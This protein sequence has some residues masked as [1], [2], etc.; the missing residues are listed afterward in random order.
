[1]EGP[2]VSGTGHRP[3]KFGGYG[4]N[5]TA[6]EVVA[7]TKSELVRL[8][9]SKVLSGMALGFDQWLAWLC[10]RQGIPFEA[11]LPFE[12]QELVWKDPN[13]RARY[14]E[15]L[16]LASTVHTVTSLT[17]AQRTNR[18]IVGIAMQKRN[19]FMVDNSTVVLAAWDGSSG[20]TA[21]CVKYATR[22]QRPVVRLDLQNLP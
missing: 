9:P 6:V 19:E 15:L 1:M 4:K 18:Q 3:E 8:R 21:N 5:P 10:V 17:A 20:G 14:H 12:G 2:V 22:K 16:K 11:C 13:A 7:R